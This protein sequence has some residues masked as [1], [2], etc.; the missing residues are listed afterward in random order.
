[1]L[2][3]AA[4]VEISC[5]KPRLAV[6]K[7]AAAMRGYDFELTD[8]EADLLFKSPCHYCG[9]RAPNRFNGID[10][11]VNKAGYVPGNVVACCRW[12][13]LAKG[14][15]PVEEFLTWLRWVQTNPPP[16]IAP[17]QC[18]FEP[19]PPMPQISPPRDKDEPIPLGDLTLKEYVRMKVWG[20]AV[21]A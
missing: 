4:T 17:V 16:M 19:K 15:R 10:R 21:G 18:E 20:T 14:S 13:N 11:V 1:M 7:K 6:Y 5:T 8:E 12:C 9:L 2:E 3:A